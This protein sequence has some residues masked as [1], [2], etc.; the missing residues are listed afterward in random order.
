MKRKLLSILVSIPLLTT[1]L[2][3]CNNKSNTE[4]TE[5]KIVS[6]PKDAVVTL[7]EG[8]SFTVE[9]NNE[10]LV[11][12]YMWQVYNG[13]IPE[14]GE[15]PFKGRTEPAKE[16]WLDLKDCISGH[17]KTYVKM[18]NV[19]NHQPL[20]K[21]RCLITDIYDNVI[22]SDEAI[23]TY[24][25]PGFNVP[26]VHVGGY[27]LQVGESLDLATTELGTGVIDF[28][29][30][31]ELK[32]SNLRY[33][34]EL[35]IS[36]NIETGTDGI[37]V[38]DELFTESKFKVTLEGDNVIHNTYW[39]PNENA[40]GIG[41]NFF[42][43]DGYLAE[44][45]ISGN[46]KLAITGGSHAIYCPGTLNISSDIV[47]NSIGSHYGTGIYAHKVILDYAQI[48]GKVNGD[49]I[50]NKNYP[51]ENG[52]VSIINDAS[53]DVIIHPQHPSVGGGIAEGM[54]SSG[55]F[56][57]KDSNVNLHMVVSGD[58]YDEDHPLVGSELLGSTNGTL[59]I[60]NSTVSL[61]YRSNDKLRDLAVS[62]YGI[63]GEADIDESKVNI[64]ID[65]EE[66]I[67]ASA[68]AGSSLVIVKSEVRL[69]CRAS[70]FV[71]GIKN[72]GEVRCTYSSINIIT[73]SYDGTNSLGLMYY[74][75]SNNDV[76]YNI[77]TNAG[78]AVG[79][80][81]KS[82]TTIQEYD[83]TYVPTHI[84]MNKIT[85]MNLS[86]ATVNQYSIYYAATGKYNV[87]ETIYSLSD[88]TKPASVL[89]MHIA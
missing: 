12:S 21:Y 38:F 42:F 18:S 4:A 76:M 7:P 19:D 60:K 24:A 43:G 36:D 73:E 39:D 72:N 67:G 1:F 45:E 28:V 27:V 40:G 30:R 77:E 69:E 66:T 83:P 54:V 17:T 75:L 74:N 14:E 26:L 49:V 15:G 89:I 5:L 57:I 50:R 20:N 70:G 3:G 65:S 48:S 84:D 62:C 22:T 31:T 34:N 46:G 61:S 68:I 71:Y 47:L 85:V 29:S 78:I 10:K 13:I 23:L 32:L 53:I 63:M 16:Q 44:V 41:L 88:T 25:N 56:N 2:V 80:Y 58:D 51:E 81:C 11:K 55:D 33:H 79:A 8:C 6:Q 35:P 64:S 37:M 59:Y 86:D 9:V 87:I 52:D 82:S